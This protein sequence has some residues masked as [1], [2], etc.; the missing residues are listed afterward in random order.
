MIAQAKVRFPYLF[1]DGSPAVMQQARGI[2]LIQVAW[3]AVRDLGPPSKN[4]GW[5]S[6]AAE[7][8]ASETTAVVTTV[9]GN[10]SCKRKLIIF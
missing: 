3:A 7:K 5:L 1:A 2:V 10:H 8:A 6:V 9:G 4:H